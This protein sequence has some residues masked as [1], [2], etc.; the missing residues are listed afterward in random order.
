MAWDSPAVP[1]E[2]SKDGLVIVYRRNL[3]ASASTLTNAG[4]VA[5]HMLVLV[6]TAHPV[7]GLSPGCE[8][9]AQVSSQVTIA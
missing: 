5:A 7:G 1:A 6:A 4:A 8:P 3:S 9:P 2:L